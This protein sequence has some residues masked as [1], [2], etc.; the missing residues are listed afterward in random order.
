MNCPAANS[1]SKIGHFAAVCRSKPGT[2]VS[3]VQGEGDSMTQHNAAMFVGM[4]NA[5]ASPNHA[6]TQHGPEL[7]QTTGSHKKPTEPGWHIKL[8]GTYTGAQVSVMPESMYE[9]VYG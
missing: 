7:T 9:T 1:C 4:V 6:D 3:Q 5:G 2:R 8:Q